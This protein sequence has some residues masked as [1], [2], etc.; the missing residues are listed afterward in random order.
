MGL[1]TSLL[2]VSAMVAVAAPVR[3]DVPDAVTAALSKKYDLTCTAVMSG[4][5]ADL[6]ASF[7]AMSPDFVETMLSGKTQKRDEVIA[8]AKQQMAI[9]K[10][11]SCTNTIDSATQPDANTIIAT[12]STKIEGTLQAPDAAHD[13]SVVGKSEDTWKNINGTWM[14]TASKELRSLVKVDG[15]VVQDDGQ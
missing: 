5:P 4:A 12:A 14:E 11:K 1:K 13:V 3:A 9:F 2:F 7:A 8:S 15:K 6:D 10:G